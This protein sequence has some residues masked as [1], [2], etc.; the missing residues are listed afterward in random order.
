M[1]KIFN[2]T[3]DKEHS[4]SV[5]IIH[6]VES[7]ATYKIGNTN[8]VCGAS[9]H[10][11]HKVNDGSKPVY[12]KTEIVETGLCKPASCDIQLTAQWIDEILSDKDLFS[13]L[14]KLK[15]QTEDGQ[16]C[17]YTRINLTIYI[18]DDDGCLFDVALFAVIKTLLQCL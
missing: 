3:K 16:S 9:T 14:D 5:N 11:V 15:T 4:S 12:F 1:A 8:V 18:L 7:S 10:I 13:Q 17:Y 6:N 2:I